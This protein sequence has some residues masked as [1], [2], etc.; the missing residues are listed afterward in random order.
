[1][2]YYNQKEGRKTQTNR[3]GRK[4]MKE[5]YVVYKVGYNYNAW[6]G[7]EELTVSMKAFANKEAA[8]EYA[9]EHHGEIKRVEVV[10]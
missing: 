1:M 3:K 9:K 10:E 5:L 2:L 8:L 7:G 6:E 4:K